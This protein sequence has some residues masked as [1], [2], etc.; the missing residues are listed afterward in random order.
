MHLIV[1]AL[2][3]IKEMQDVLVFYEILL[4]LKPYFLMCMEDPSSSATKPNYN[5]FEF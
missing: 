1:P 4:Y 2:S 5:D 3:K